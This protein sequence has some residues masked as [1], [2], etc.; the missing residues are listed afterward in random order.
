MIFL[1][2]ASTFWRLLLAHDLAGCNQHELFPANS[3]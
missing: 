3:D 2:E 1:A